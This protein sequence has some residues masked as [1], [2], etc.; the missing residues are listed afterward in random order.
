MDSSRPLYHSTT[1]TGYMHFENGSYWLLY[2]DFSG[3]LQIDYWSIQAIREDR[4]RLYTLENQPS[5]YAWYSFAT[6][7][8]DS[9]LIVYRNCTGDVSHL[10]F[11]LSSPFDRIM[12][13]CTTDNPVTSDIA[14]RALRM[15][16]LTSGS[17]SPPFPPGGGAALADGAESLLSSASLDQQ[18]VLMAALALPHY[19]PNVNMLLNLMVAEDDLD[20]VHVAYYGDDTV[21][22][23]SIYQE[24][25]VTTGAGP[26]SME[27]AR[28]LLYDM[29]V[30]GR[31]NTSSKI[32]Y[33]NPNKPKSP[34][35]RVA[36]LVIADALK[37]DLC[38]AISL[39][40]LTKETA[41]CVAPCYHVFEKESIQMWLSTSST[42]PE[43]REVCSL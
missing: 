31:N 20:T 43:C 33:D 18:P 23:P 10:D 36:D 22:N 8:D 42:C 29:F 37:Q 19:T 1:R 41:V 15:P 11:S 3:N 27:S 25:P 32:P 28:I 9:T 5:Y 14:Y 2:T 26:S 16:P 34:L 24:T 17:D 6:V 39:N 38:C 4:M 30:A 40:P 7:H 21:P 12:P 35:K 13:Y